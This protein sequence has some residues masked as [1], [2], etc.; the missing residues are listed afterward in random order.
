MRGHLL[1][2]LPRISSVATNDVH[3]RFGVMVVVRACL[4]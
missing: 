3:C 4:E 2:Y 1:V